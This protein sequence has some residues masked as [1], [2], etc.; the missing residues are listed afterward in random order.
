MVQEIKDKIKA[1]YGTYAVYEHVHKLPKSA[2][3]NLFAG[4]G[5]KLA[6]KALEKEFGI[7][8]EAL[9]QAIIEEKM[10]TVSKS[11]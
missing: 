5:N 1:K 4:R 10:K 3:G 8:P 11:G 6:L 9:V 2:L 7:S